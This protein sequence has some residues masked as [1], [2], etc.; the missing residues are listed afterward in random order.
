MTGAI[1]IWKLNWAEPQWLVDLVSKWCRL[2]G[3]SSARSVRETEEVS[4]GLAT[5]AA[6]S[7]LLDL[8][9]V[10]RILPEKTFPELQEEDIGYFISYPHNHRAPL[11][12]LS[13]NQNSHTPTQSQGGGT[14]IAYPNER[15]FKILFYVATV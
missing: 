9:H 2:A 4:Y 10:N 14:W 15:L 11:L 3:W 1:V 6:M 5:T 12:S 7:E 8:L 13:I